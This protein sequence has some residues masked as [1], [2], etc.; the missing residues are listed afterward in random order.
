M[1]IVSL[2]L[3]QKAEESVSL[4]NAYTV[5]SIF[6]TIPSTSHTALIRI[7]YRDQVLYLC[8]GAEIPVC[9]SD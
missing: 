5:H 2:G 7:T 8:K 4:E 9:Y 3:D 1:S 6:R